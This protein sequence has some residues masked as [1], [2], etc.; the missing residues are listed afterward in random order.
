MNAFLGVD[1]LPELLFMGKVGIFID[2]PP[3]SGNRLSD[4]NGYPYMYV[5]K[6]EDILNWVVDRRKGFSSILLRDYIYDYDEKTGFPIKVEEQYRFMRRADNGVEVRIL[7]KDS[8][9]IEDPIMLDIPEIPFVLAEISE[10]LLTDIAE[11]QISLMNLASS[12]MIF[13]QK[14]NFPF[15]TEQ[16]D[17][18]AEFSDHFI[19]TDEGDDGESADAQTAKSNEIAVGP[20][21]G[22]RYSKELERPGFIFPSPE[23]MKVSMQK[24]EQIKTEIRLLLNL[25]IKNLQSI[26]SSAESKIQDES[27]KQSGI[28]TIGY[29][30]ETAERQIAKIW[31]QYEGSSGDIT[32][33]YPRD[34]SLKT[35]YDRRSEA[36]DLFE[37]QERIPSKTYQ[38][39]IAKQSVKVLLGPKIENNVLDAIYA[40]INQAPNMS[41]NPKTLEIDIERGLVS[42]ELASELRGYPDGEVKKAQKEHGD[43]LARIA[44]SQGKNTEYNAARGIPD[45]DPDVENSAREEK[46]ESRE[47]DKDDV[48]KDKTRGES[49][50]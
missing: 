18:S 4:D 42:T 10:S 36:K 6:R 48:V 5:Y 28:S 9:D 17:P 44:N 37:L 21:K 12:D 13:C 45:A 46:K 27:S 11:H 3:I 43:R 38:K 7:S 8:E 26:R 34:Y 32:I 30:L 2:R 22:R 41:S 49:K 1:I 25:T 14:S 33:K 29:S 31:A 35:E 16:F 47:T 39:E 20:T 50:E 19:Q 15:Y 23:P 40:E 24:Q